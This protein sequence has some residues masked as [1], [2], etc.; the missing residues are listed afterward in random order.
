MR[1]RYVT[2]TRA[3]DWGLAI[4]DWRLAISPNPL[5]SGFATLRYS[6]PRSGAA[7]LGVY[8]VSGRA[9]MWQTLNVARNGAATLNLR[10][11]SNGVY[12]VKLSSDSFS[13]SRKLVVQR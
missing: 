6:L 7:V 2:E 13:V 12:L 1:N 10:H 3:G 4:G 11:L 9:V 8:D 5:A